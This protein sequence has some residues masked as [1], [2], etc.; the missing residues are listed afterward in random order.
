MY[1]G[2]GSAGMGDFLGVGMLGEK[3]SRVK[4]AQTYAVQGWLTS[5][6]GSTLEGDHQFWIIIL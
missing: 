2:L 1:L 4:G 3:N 6:V 5:W